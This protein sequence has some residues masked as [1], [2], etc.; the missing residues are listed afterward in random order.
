MSKQKVKVIKVYVSEE[1][2]NKAVAKY[3]SR[4]VSYAVN[5]LV[6]KDLNQKQ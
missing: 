3:G 6:Q 4:C 5:K 2:K 1:T